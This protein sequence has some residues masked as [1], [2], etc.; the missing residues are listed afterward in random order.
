MSVE[1]ALVLLFALVLGNYWLSRSVLYPPLWFCA[2]WLLDLGLYWLNLTPVDEIHPQ[3]IAVIGFG[4]LLFSTGGFLALYLP[5]NL[6]TA[7]FVITRFPQRNNIVKPAVTLFILAGVPIMVRNLL[8][9]AATGYGTTIMQRARTGEADTNPFATY[10]MLW[11]TYAATLF[12]LERRDKYFWLMAGIALVAGVLSTGRLPIFMLVGSLVCVHLIVT[13]RHTLRVAFAFARLPV[14][15]FLILFFGLF[16]TNKDTSIFEAS[17]IGEL[18]II[19]FVGYVVGPTAALD[20]F[21]QNPN[22]YPEAPNH[23]FRFFLGIATHFHLANYIAP[24]PELHIDVPFP[25]NVYTVYRTYIQ[26]FG[27]YGALAAMAVIGLLHTM[28]YRKARTGSRLGIYFFAATF[29]QVLMVIFSDEYASFGT[30]IDLTLFAAIYIALR[31][32]PL[33][34]L[35]RVGTGYGTRDPIK[36]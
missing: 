30:Y 3:T 6:F 7:Q 8:A 13:G 26:D 23:T 25:T 1:H 21:L 2:M 19:F 36:V 18:L 20:V 4:A 15:G 34:I 33:R 31:S 32:L 14:I 27:L 29:Y 9:M 16:F 11:S 35:P 22:N 17:G 12:L 10:F 28:L 5:S 24:S